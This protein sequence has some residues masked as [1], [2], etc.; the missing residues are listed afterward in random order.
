MK[1]AHN[2]RDPVRAFRSG[3][4]VHDRKPL[5]LPLF[6]A[7]ERRPWKR[8]PRAASASA[9]PA[10]GVASEPTE[11]QGGRLSAGGRAAGGGGS[12]SAFS[13]PPAHPLRRIAGRSAPTGRRRPTEQRTAPMRSCCLLKLTVTSEVVAPMIGPSTG[14]GARWSSLPGTG[15]Q[16]VG[17]LHRDQCC[18]RKCRNDGSRQAFSATC[19][20]CGDNAAQRIVDRRRIETSFMAC[21]KFV[22]SIDPHGGRSTLP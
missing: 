22:E 19:V 12:C 17:Q 4:A 21:R 9:A 8:R 15:E 5:S 11:R 1:H 13:V 3:T 14:A 2:N 7:V 18:G 6:Q 20:S 16:I 10:S